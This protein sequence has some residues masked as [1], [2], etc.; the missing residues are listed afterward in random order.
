VAIRSRGPIFSTATA[1][2]RTTAQ[3]CV[4]AAAKTLGGADPMAAPVMSDGAP[5]KGDAPAEDDSDKAEDQVED[6]F[7]GG[8]TSREDTHKKA[9]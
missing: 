5:A 1:G 9:Q 2:V 7:G 8:P 4:S 6:S 3:T